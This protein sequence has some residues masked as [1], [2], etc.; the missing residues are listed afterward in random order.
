MDRYAC[1]VEDVDERV[2]VGGSAGGK[3]RTVTGN[4]SHFLRVLVR[5]REQLPP[6][7][8]CPKFRIRKKCLLVAFVSLSDRDL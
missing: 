2:L 7:K 4:W 3:R 6:K 1:F 8:L 5:V